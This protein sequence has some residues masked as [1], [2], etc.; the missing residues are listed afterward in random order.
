M[1]LLTI[2]Y[3][4][5]L[6]LGS[7]LCVALIIFL[8]RISRTA[9][10]IEL[11]IKDLTLSIKPFVASATNLSEKLN[12]LSESADDQLSVTKHIVA[13]VNDRVDT[14]LDLEEKIRRGF[15]GP[16]LD[17]IKSLSAIVNGISAFWSAYKRK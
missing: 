15:E 12:Q 9:K 17:V 16:V 6:A 5:L 14:I 4:I 11:E 10:E 13:K 7:A 1:N 3:V 2:M 8:G